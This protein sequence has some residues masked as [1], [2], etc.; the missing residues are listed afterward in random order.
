MRKIILLFLL[1]VLSCFYPRPVSAEGEFAAD[2]DVTYTVSENGKT[3]VNQRIVLTNLQPDIYPKQYSI[4]VDTQ[5]LDNISA[6]DAAGSIIPEIITNSGKTQILVTFNDRI[7]GIGRKLSFT[8]AYDNL[9]IAKKNG[10]IWEIIIPGIADNRDLGTYQVR[11]SVPDSFGPL[12]FRKPEPGG[13]TYWTKEQMLKGGIN[14]AY[15]ISQFYRLELKYYIE[16]SA[17][18]TKKTEIALPPDT[19]YQ[20]VSIVSLEPKPLDIKRDADGNWLATY[21]LPA[22]SQLE[23]ITQIRVS[24]MLLPVDGSTDTLTNHGAYLQATANWPVGFSEIT[25]LSRQHKTPREIY[26]YTVRTLVYDYD[27]V[28]DNPLR[29]GA[30]KALSDPGSSLCTEFTDVFVTL[31]RANGIPARQVIGYAYTTN[32]K[33]RPLSL[34]TDV[35]HAWPEYYDNQLKRWVPVDPTWG[36]TTGGIDYFTTLDFNH[37]VFAINGIRDDYPYP[38]GAYR[39]PGTKGKILDVN[40]SQVDEAAH[41]EAVYELEVKFPKMVAAGL[42]AQGKILVKNITGVS[43]NNIMVNVI[44]Q[45]PLS[46]KIETVNQIPPFT[47]VTIPVSVKSDSFLSI[48]RGSV[49]ASLDGKRA[50]VFYNIRP[51]H[52]IILVTVIIAIVTTLVLWYVIIRSTSPMLKR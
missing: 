35:L 9:D 21:E 2:Y 28:S 25:S 31:A 37:I 8:L 12:A 40:F 5:N 49:T 20:K 15:G 22:K 3:R 39:Q 51:I 32:A 38:A 6:Q 44:T 17:S 4:I 42:T 50:T 13:G 43:A 24:L 41:P 27:R 11:L 18:V 36:H 23:I 19:L 1:P 52:A 33:L 45:P 10:T 46:E 26:D 48:G 16:N 14:A 34:V 29:K 7:V 30:L 47:T